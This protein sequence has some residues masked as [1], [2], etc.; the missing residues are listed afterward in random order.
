MTEIKPTREQ[1]E[2][3]V[4]IRNSGITNMFAVSVV[5]DLSC[6]DLTRENCF[7][8]MKHFAELAE[9]YGVEI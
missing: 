4:N 8:I 6:T 7:Y 3:Y 2:D 1:F 9:E 5:C